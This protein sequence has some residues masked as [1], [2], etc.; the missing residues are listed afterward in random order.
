MASSSNSTN[1]ISNNQDGGDHRRWSKMK[2]DIA[3]I[4]MA[5]EL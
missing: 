4:M 1:K 5:G 3:T 2:I